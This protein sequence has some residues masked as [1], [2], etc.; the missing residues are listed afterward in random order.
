M[1][2]ATPA[3]DYQLYGRCPMRTVDILTIYSLS[4]VLVA[5]ASELAPAAEPDAMS[6]PTMHEVDM[7]KEASALRIMAAA[8]AHAAQNGNH[9]PPVFS[10]WDTLLAEAGDAAGESVPVP[11][12][13]AAGYPVVTWT[14]NDSARMSDLM[15][16]GVDGII[17][18]RPDLLRAAVEQFDSSLIG[19]DG[20]IDNAR[21]DA[22]GHRGA[23]DLRPE[24]TLPAM[25][26]GLDHLVTTLETDTGLTA[27]GISVLSH[28]PYLMAD[29]CR[30]ASGEPYTVADEVLIKNLS[31]R[32]LQHAF[33]CDGLPRGDPQTNDLDLSPVSV[34]FTAATDLPHPY[35]MPTVAQLFD[36]VAFYADY[37]RGG[38]G[39]RHENAEQR[40]KN[41][42]RVRFNIETKL[43][44]GTDRDEKG[45][46]L[47][48]R[49]A[50]P[51]AFVTG[52]AGTISARG[53]QDR[54][55]IQSFDF[56]T[57][58]LTHEQHPSIR[59]IFLFGSIPDIDAQCAGTTWLPDLFCE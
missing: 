8:K 54:A 6:G 27:D 37:Y 4:V 58:L 28:D 55:D 57:L 56:R 45:I 13:Q 24:N 34:A 1:R 29:K 19:A 43:N 30:R 26:A 3:S 38:D 53:M 25:E 11:S 23:R 46:V 52:L 47:A 5:G 36:F 39:V 44:P 12:M 32:E 49:T 14:V 33:V 17:S 41:A 42:A 21:M 15:R 10:P 22:Q 20:L 7:T 40:A 2:L 50:G 48:D 35:A 31:L 9:K 16:L 59:T 18:D 51:Q